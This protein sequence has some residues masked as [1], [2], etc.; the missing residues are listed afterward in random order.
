MRPRNSIQV[1]WIAL[2]LWCSSCSTAPRPSARP[3]P[4][5]VAFS[6]LHRVRMEDTQGEDHMRFELDE[7]SLGSLNMR[8]RDVLSERSFTILSG[9][10]PTDETL[11]EADEELALIQHARQTTDADVLVT[12]DLQYGTAIYHAISD[13]RVHASPFWWVP[14]PQYWFAQDHI[15]G[16]DLTLTF[17][18][19]DLA[20][21]SAGE[22]DR[23][24]E[25]RRWFFSHAVTLDDLGMDFVDRAGDRFMPYVKSFFAPSTLLVRKG[26]ELEEI[27]RQRFIKRL[28][29]TVAVEI[30]RNR[31]SL[32]RNDH[33]YSFFLVST[34]LEVERVSPTL[35]KVS[36]TLEH[37]QGRSRNQPAAL[38]LFAGGERDP[39][40]MQALSQ[41]DVA[42]AFQEDAST[43]AASRY[44]FERQVQVKP[45][46]RSLRLHV[47]VGSGVP[48]LREFTLALPE[49]AEPA[50][51]VSFD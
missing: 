1:L 11:T 32:I 38:K 24:L 51:E 44:H 39:G 5:H 2:L 33:D 14:G 28:A 16:V 4:Y 26:P 25:L 31:G 10:E 49:Y 12:F 45:Q 30:A 7:D 6:P 46:A 40:P 36:F 17:K 27:L 43:K 20:R 18:L 47:A 50:P 48:S 34:D 8:L 29:D 21:C 13:A 41:N 19:F 23:P 9:L 15:Y 35:A 42:E 37:Q 22:K 3:L